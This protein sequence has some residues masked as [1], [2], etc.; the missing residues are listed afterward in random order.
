MLQSVKRAMKI[1]EQDSKFDSRMHGCI[2]KFQK[3][4]TDKMSSFSEP[5]QNV[6]MNE[7]KNIFTTKTTRERN[8]EFM[9]KHN[10]DYQCLVEGKNFSFA[11]HN[12][13]LHSILTPLHL[14]WNIYTIIQP[15]WFLGAKSIALIDPEKSDH[16]VKLLFQLDSSNSGLDMKVIFNFISKK[17]CLSAIIF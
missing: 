17:I 16:A 6:L 2:I 4:V 15:L 13:L 3:F 5:V 14:I 1:L 7:T 12:I 9:Q 8:E 10:K 11:K